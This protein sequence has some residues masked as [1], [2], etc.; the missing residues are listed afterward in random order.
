MITSIGLSDDVELRLV[1]TG[2]AASLAE[3]YR[4]N[5]EHLSAWDPVRPEG[6]YTES[7][8]LDRISDL[9]ESHASGRAVPFLLIR[10]GAPIGAL[11][12]ND[13]VRGA[14][15][16]GHLGYWIDAAQQG[17]GLMTKAVNAVVDL[18]FGPLGLHRLQASTLPHN[19]GS[20]KVLTNCGFQRIGMAEKYL[21][22]QDRWQDHVLFQL[23]AP[24]G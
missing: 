5:R 13:V 11:N 18:A 6:F 15:E 2:D 3:L 20:Q 7:G 16:N 14:F 23:V 4:R 19:T 17:K 10:A 9:L 24:E 21:R 8:Q 22:I 12:I 1:T